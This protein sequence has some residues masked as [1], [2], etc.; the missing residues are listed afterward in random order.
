MYRLW[1]TIWKPNLWFNYSIYYKNLREFV[2]KL[3]FGLFVLL[4]RSVSVCPEEVGWKPHFR[5]TWRPAKACLPPQGRSC[6]VHFHTQPRH[7]VCSLHLTAQV[8]S[9]NTEGVQLLELCWFGC[10]HHR[11][12][13]YHPPRVLLLSFLT[14][15]H[16]I[17]FG[18]V[19]CVTNWEWLQSN[20]PFLSKR[21]SLY[22]HKCVQYC[23]Y[24][25]DTELFNNLSRIKSG[26]E[27]PWI[28]AIIC[29]ILSIWRVQS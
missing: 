4:D 23:Y 25:W 10:L 24:F 8:H 12:W 13:I 14:P 9:F 19:G 7:F 6:C 16:I 26:I 1:Y 11:S 20:F 29:V 22:I 17:L 21:S 3:F 27:D 5:L 18:P 28:Y 15:V 2:W